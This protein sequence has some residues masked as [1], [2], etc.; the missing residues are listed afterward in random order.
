ME[1]ENDKKR[2]RKE[3]KTGFFYNISFFIIL[4]RVSCDHRDCLTVAIDWSVE[5]RNRKEMAVT[6]GLI[7]IRPVFLFF[8]LGTGRFI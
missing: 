4:C 6:G 7:Y 5:L 1:E 8:F 2:R 3:R